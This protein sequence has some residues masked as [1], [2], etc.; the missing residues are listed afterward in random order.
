[1]GNYITFVAELW[2]VLEGLNFSHARVYNM[3]EVQVNNSEVFDVITSSNQNL[4]K[5]LIIIRII[6]SMIRQ[7]WKIQFFHIF[8]E[9]NR[10]AY[11]LTKSNINLSGENIYYEG[12]PNHMYDIYLEDLRENYYRKIVNM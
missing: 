9:A 3:M 5:W 6:K 1:M 2:G 7:D 4:G 10:C 12:W 11:A 8:R